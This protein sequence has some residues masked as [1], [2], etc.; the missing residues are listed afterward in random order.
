MRLPPSQSVSVGPSSQGLSRSSS[1]MPTHQGM[2]P[3]P[4]ASVSQERRPPTTTN[5]NHASHRRRP[6]TSPFFDEP[7]DASINPWVQHPITH[8]YK[9]QDGLESEDSIED[10]RLSIIK[11]RQQAHASKTLHFPSTEPQDTLRRYTME[12]NTSSSVT[13]MPGMSDGTVPMPMS[14]L[15]ASRSHPSPLFSR[16]EARSLETDVLGPATRRALDLLK[17]DI[18][19]LHGRVDDLRQE[20][21]ERDHRGKRSWAAA[22]PSSAGDASGE[23]WEGWRWVLK[24]AAKHAALNFILCILL[25]NILY[26]RDSVGINFW[27]ALKLAMVTKKKIA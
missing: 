27:Q 25:L 17:S 1:V 20:L 14:L 12:S 8:H 16:S 13:A 10:E 6:S 5:T 18:V 23:A 26:R 19:A 4:V 11:A 15:D 21:V 3:M 22:L 2:R 9:A 7:F 24:T